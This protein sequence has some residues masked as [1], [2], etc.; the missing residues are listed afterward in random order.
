MWN[1][2]YQKCIESGLFII[3]ESIAK[4][5]DGSEIISRTPMVTGKGQRYFI[6]KFLE[7]KDQEALAAITE[8]ELKLE[9]E[10]DL[11][12]EDGNDFKPQLTADELNALD[13]EA[14]AV[15]NNI[16]KSDDSPMLDDDN[17]ESIDNEDEELEDIDAT[18]DELEAI[19]TNAELEAI[20]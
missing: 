13:A 3:K 16:G 1:V 2:P 6:S 19:D 10:T 20:E 18:S 12:A 15:A 14:E 8:E 5:K 11:F 4:A 17:L 9:S 7:T